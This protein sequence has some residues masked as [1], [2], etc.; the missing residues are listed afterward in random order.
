M[1]RRRLFDGP[2]GEFLRKY[3]VIRRLAVVAAIVI[4]IYIIGAKNDWWPKSH[5]DPKSERHITAPAE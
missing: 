3:K 5:Q 1:P 2:L 4:G